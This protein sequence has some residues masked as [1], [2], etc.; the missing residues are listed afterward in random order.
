MPGGKGGGK[1]WVMGRAWGIRE[2]VPHGQS[3]K[4]KT[5]AARSS[6]MLVLTVSSGWG[7]AE[8][9]PWKLP[10]A[11]YVKDQKTVFGGQ[12]RAIGGGR[13]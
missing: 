7:G 13:A 8:D 12:Q 3:Q 4:G 11:I 10:K 9:G 6:E 1:G 2:E 5:G